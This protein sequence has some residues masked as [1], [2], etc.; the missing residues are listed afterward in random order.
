MKILIEDYQRRLKTAEEMIET[1][2]NTG[3]INDQKKLERLNTKA[4][5]YRTFIAELEREMRNPLS[6]YDTWVIQNWFGDSPDRIY[7]SKEVAEEVATKDQFNYRARQRVIHKDMSDEEF[8][9]YFESS[10]KHIKYKVMSLSDAMCDY[11]EQAVFDAQ[12]DD[13][14]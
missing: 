9:T 2:K 11:K 14:I 7:L 13:L 3:S 10:H 4:S 1:T 12:H 5:E 8:E 6:V